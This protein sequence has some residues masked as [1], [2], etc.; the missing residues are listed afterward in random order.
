MAMFIY[1]NQGVS[2]TVE[3]KLPLPLLILYRDWSGVDMT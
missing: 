2:Q 3:T 1:N